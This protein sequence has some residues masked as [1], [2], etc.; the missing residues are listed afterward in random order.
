MTIFSV[1]FGAGILLMT[2]RVEASGKRPGVVHYRRMGWL[3]VVGL[4]HAYLLWSGD[5]LVA[6]GLCGSLAY[7]GRRLRPPTLF[8]LASMLL[9]ASPASWIAFT[10]LSPTEAARWLSWLPH[11]LPPAQEIAAYRGGWLS[12]M[13]P[14]IQA[15]FQSETLEFALFT[16]WRGTGLMLA[17]IGFLKLGLLQGRCSARTYWR[18]I[19][20]G[21][22]I[23][24][25]VALFG[26]CFNS[27]SS[28]TSASLFGWQFN[29]WSSLLV[30]AGWVG[31]SI[32]AS[33]SV[34]LL[35]YTRR[36]A[37]VGRLALTNY[38]MQTLICTTIFYGHGLGLFGKVKGAGQL[39]IVAMVWLVQL[40]FSP[41]W[42]RHF[43]YGPMEWLWRCLTYARWERFSRTV[44]P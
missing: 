20:V 44:T 41:I 37:A 18:M 39:V 21:L 4:V 27:L 22:C 25:P 33:S 42:L 16:F 29:Y 32:L 3:T 30:S 23:G 1:L 12:Q 38:L 43:L 8:V 31:A 13:A 5:I 15:A 40:T 36:V 2:G 26:I 34:A 9:A 17:G 14:R 11:P 6:Y 19:G 10:L 7:L 28:H 24:I 35:P